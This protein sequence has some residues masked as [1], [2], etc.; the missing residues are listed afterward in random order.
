VSDPSAYLAEL[1][2]VARRLLANARQRDQLLHERA[3]IVWRIVRLG[4]LR[5]RQ[6]AEAI[7]KAL[8]DAQFTDDEIRE[9]GVSEANIRPI[10]RLPREP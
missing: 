1:V 4:G 9:V 7:R 6:A 5:P 10:G 3:R 8:V 2:D